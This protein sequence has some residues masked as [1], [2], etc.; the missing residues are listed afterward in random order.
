[1][2]HSEETSI[3]SI[4]LHRVGNKSADEPMSL[5]TQSLELSE[6]LSDLLLHFFISPFKEPEFYQFHHDSNLKLN[7]VY[8]Y[9]SDIFNQNDVLFDASV[10]LAKHLYNKSIHPNIKSGEF[11]TVYFKDCILDGEVLDAVGLFKSESK[12]TFLKVYPKGEDFEIQSETGINLNKLDKACLVFNAE[13]EDGYEVVALDNLNKTS[14]ARYWFDDFLSV[15]QRE[16]KFF[17]TERTMA[18]CKNFVTQHLPKEFE[19]D[20]ADQADLLNKSMEY[21]KENTNCDMSIF[22]DEVMQQPEVIESFKHYR[23]DFQLQNDLELADT[24]EISRQAVK[25]KARFFKSVIKLDKN[26]HIYIHGKREYVKK[27]FDRENGLNY[28]QLY[29]EKED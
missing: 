3:K 29:Y 20:K 16:D 9:I 8:G 10:K 15:R 11:Y 24:F 5:S 2:I 27:G 7:E 28:Y 13:K 23:Q 4:A 26:F 6:E 22:A 17:H 21:F 12:E 18:L 14:D 1:M 19:V 25:K